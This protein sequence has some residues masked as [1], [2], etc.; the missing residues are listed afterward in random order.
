MKIIPTGK[1]RKIVLGTNPVQ[2]MAIVVGIT[3]VNL[4]GQVF[5]V[6]QIIESTD[7]F[8][9]FGSVRY[10]V[11]YRIGNGQERL[12]K[13]FINVPISI[14]YDSGEDVSYIN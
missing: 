12:W 13:S 9:L 5:K 3:E 14:E 2:G 8:F 4:K 10:F 1:I 7:N 11:F 6:S